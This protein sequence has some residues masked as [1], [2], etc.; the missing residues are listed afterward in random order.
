MRVSIDSALETLTCAMLE[1]VSF[2]GVINSPLEPLIIPLF[3][4]G[5]LSFVQKKK[6]TG[7]VLFLLLSRWR[8]KEAVCVP[9]VRLFY[10]VIIIGAGCACVAVAFMDLSCR[11][12]LLMSGSH[13]RSSR[14]LFL[15]WPASSSVGQFF[16]ARALL[17][18]FLRVCIIF[19][20]MRY[21]ILC[22]IHQLLSCSCHSRGIL[23]IWECP[24]RTAA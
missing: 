3:L 14:L 4:C 8:G 7:S 5:R 19:F 21:R 13:F 9:P 18:Q 10:S 23:R 20:A 17:G 1:V 16:L 15:T 6:S 2:S 11:R 22:R 12:K 24:A